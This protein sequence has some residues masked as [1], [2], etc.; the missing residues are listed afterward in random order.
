MYVSQL[1]E[2][3]IKQLRGATVPSSFRLKPHE[4]LPILLRTQIFPTCM[5]RGQGGT[6]RVEGIFPTLAADTSVVLDPNYF[7]ELI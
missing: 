2:K 4:L 5:V 6:F 7:V 1:L 3:N